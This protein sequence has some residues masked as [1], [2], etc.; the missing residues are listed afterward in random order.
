M[1]RDGVSS[2]SD[3]KVDNLIKSG[4]EEVR[5]E[6]IE[7]ITDKY[8]LSHFWKDKFKIF[9]PLEEEMLDNKAYTDMLRLKLANIRKLI[10]KNLEILKNAKTPDDQEKYQKVH[11]ELKKTEKEISDILGIVI[12]R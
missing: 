2:N 10:Q 4:N 11:I 1:F 7:M 12:S 6:V 8:E 9:V 3:F 5:S